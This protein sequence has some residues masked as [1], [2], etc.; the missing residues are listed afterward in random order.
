MTLATIRLAILGF[1]PYQI[2]IPNLGLGRSFVSQLVVSFHLKFLRPNV[3]VSPQVPD[4]AL[5]QPF[6]NSLPP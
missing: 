1:N 6:N 3:S 5:G 4:E 2:I